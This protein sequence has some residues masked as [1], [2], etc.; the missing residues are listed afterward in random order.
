MVGELMSLHRLFCA[1]TLLA[2]TV[3]AAIQTPSLAVSWF[4]DFNDMNFA[5]GT[6]VTWSP[7]AAT[8]GTYT[9][10]TGDFALSAPGV[11]QGGTGNNDSLIATVNTTFQDTFV[12]TQ[13]LV[14]PG[15]N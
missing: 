8:P 13:T 9:V 6:P 10:A 15:P 3:L 1:P 14:L 5:D 12:R 7:L 11:V 4:D 2:V